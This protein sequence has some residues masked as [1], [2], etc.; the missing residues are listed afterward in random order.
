MFCPRP[1]QKQPERPNKVFSGPEGTSLCP[2]CGSDLIRWTDERLWSWGRAGCP[3]LS[4]AAILTIV[5]GEKKTLLRPFC[6]EHQRCVGAF[7]RFWQ[8]LQYSEL[9]LWR[10]SCS[11]AR[12]RKIEWDKEKREA[13]QKWQECLLIERLEKGGG[14]RRGKKGG[15]KD[16]LKA[17]KSKE[18]R[19]LTE[20]VARV[21]RHSTLHAQTRKKHELRIKWLSAKVYRSAWVWVSVWAEENWNDN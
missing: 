14:Q 20:C 12:V 6:F 18:S 15:L 16:S 1:V 5:L 3:N 8:S 10:T 7:F 13:E 11:R 17:E 2:F 19:Q 4:L 21:A 9:T